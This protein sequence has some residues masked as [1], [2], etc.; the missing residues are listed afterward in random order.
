MKTAQ[1]GLLLPVPPMG[2][3]LCFELASSAPAMLREALR[4][5]TPLVDG[6]HAVLAVGPSLVAALGLEVPGLREL[7]ALVGPQVSVPSTPIALWCWL[8]GT[9][10]GVLIHQGRALAEA[11][12]PEFKLTQVVDGFRHGRGPNGHGRDLTGYED[13]TENPQDAD[14][15]R[16]AL[17]RQGAGLKG[18]SFVAVQ[19][20][21]HDLDA[22]AAMPPAAQDAMIGRKRRGNAEIEDAPASA[23]VKRTAQESFSPEA[24][25]LRRS[26]PWTAGEQAGLMFVAFGKSL[27]AFEAQLTRMVG[28]ED[29][30]TDALFAMSRPVTGSY[31]WCPPVRQTA[32]G[33]QLDWRQLR[34]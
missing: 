4:R 10:R 25:V 15:E 31:L 32:Q 5:V 30:V 34:V 26:M 9:D 6:E 20:W 23:H 3:Y 19:Q 16:A 18:G 12:A 14:A 33:P 24:F 2:R 13:G 29:G 7:P 27:D 22:F 1:A 17:I 8:R 21:L 28:L 11:L